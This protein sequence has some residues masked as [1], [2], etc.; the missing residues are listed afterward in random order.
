MIFPQSMIF[1]TYINNNHHDINNV[2]SKFTL[3]T[4]LGLQQHFA[5]IK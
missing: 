4:D 1:F 3:K 2:F 5:I